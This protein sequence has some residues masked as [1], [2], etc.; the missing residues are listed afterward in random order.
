MCEFVCAIGILGVQPS[1]G[2]GPCLSHV[3]FICITVSHRM[4]G[5]VFA[6]RMLEISA[7]TEAP[8]MALVRQP[9]LFS[10]TSQSE[11]ICT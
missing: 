3:S 7:V 10:C 8:A 11:W 6:K 9:P 4:S 2:F 1:L 5:F